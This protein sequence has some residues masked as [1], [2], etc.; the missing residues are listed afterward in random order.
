MDLF[1]QEKMKYT[2]D[3]CYML[4]HFCD[5][6][7]YK[8]VYSAE[9]LKYFD[10]TK[11]NDCKGSDDF[12]KCF[13]EIPDFY[14]TREIYDRSDKIYYVKDLNELKHVLILNALDKTLSEYQIIKEY[15][16]KFNIELLI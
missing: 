8:K 12:F 9:K 3:A 4:Y 14:T 13:V 2:H 7:F 16:N 15:C 11:L 10:F 6:Y 5:N 1:L